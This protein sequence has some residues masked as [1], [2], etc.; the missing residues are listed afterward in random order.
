MK[1]FTITLALALG[2]A[3]T[4]NAAEKDANMM[5]GATS[6]IQQFKGYPPP[7]VNTAQQYTLWAKVANIGTTVPVNMKRIT[8]LCGDGDGCTFRLGMYNWD[9]SGRTASRE[10][11]MYYNPVNFVWRT[12]AGDIPGTDDNRVVEHVM[13]AWS[14]YFTD[15]EYVNT[16]GTDSVQGFGLL[17]WTNYTADCVLTITD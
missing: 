4:A 13:N 6:Q 8:S 12:S 15:G 5:P 14:C 3:V 17:S 7:P 9:G 11:L 2:L 10:S 16:L 1:L